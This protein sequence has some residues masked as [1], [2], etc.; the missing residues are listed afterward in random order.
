MKPKIYFFDDISK[1]N[2]GLNKILTIIKKDLPDEKVGI[3]IHFGEQNNTTHIK[4]NNFEI[5]KEF[6][7]DPYYIECNVLYKGRRTTTTEH[8][9]LAKEHGF[10]NMPIK[11]LDGEVGMDAIEIPINLKHI[12]NAKIG[13]GIKEFSQMISMA[14]FKGHMGTG[15]GGTIKNIGMGLASRTGKLEMHSSAIPVVGDGCTLCG[16]CQENCDFNAIQ[17]DK[18]AIIDKNICAGCSRCIAMCPT[19][20]IGPD[21]GSDD[22]KKVIERLSEYALAVKSLGKWWYINFL[23]DMTQE[24]DCMPI[25]QEPIIKDLGILAS[26]DPLALD[27]ASMDIITKREGHDPFKKRNHVDSNTLFKHGEEIGLGSLDYTLVKL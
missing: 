21:W 4:P 14:H 24:C 12:K 13:N 27:K 18:K 5:I 15:F 26:N 3:K 7:N 25:T 10:T 19:G 20:T 16:V 9:K 17:L 8:I 23:I 2:E 1:I 6:Y 11:I 22:N